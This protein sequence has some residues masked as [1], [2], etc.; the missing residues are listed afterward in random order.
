[1]KFFIYLYI[2]EEADSVGLISFESS[3]GVCGYVATYAGAD[4]ES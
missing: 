1:M 2:Y 3:V 4:P